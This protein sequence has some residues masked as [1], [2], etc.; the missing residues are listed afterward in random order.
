MKV[1]ED[2]EAVIKMTVKG[3]SPKLRH[4]ARTH[5]IDLDWLFERVREDPGVFIKYISTKTQLADMLTK[6]AFSAHQWQALCHLV[7]IGP[8]QKSS[9]SPS[10]QFLAMCEEREAE[11]DLVAQ[12]K[13][14]TH[15]RL[16]KMSWQ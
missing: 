10:R 2:N 15:H 13:K 6:G 7:Q 14:T 8:P 5:R 11:G 16:H 12:V 4:V 9:T 3:R 1:L